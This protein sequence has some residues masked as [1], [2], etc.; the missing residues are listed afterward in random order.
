[1]EANQY[2]EVDVERKPERRHK[3]KDWD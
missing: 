2:E 1:V 3:R